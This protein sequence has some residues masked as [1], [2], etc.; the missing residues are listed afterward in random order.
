MFADRFLSLAGDVSRA[1]LIKY[2]Y[3]EAIEEGLKGEYHEGGGVKLWAVMVR[4]LPN[5]FFGE[6]PSTDEARVQSLSG[7]YLPNRIEKRNGL[8]TTRKTLQAGASNEYNWLDASMDLTL[9]FRPFSG[10]SLQGMR[11]FLHGLT[12][13]NGRTI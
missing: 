3:K 1:N 12:L 13:N 6:Y 7:T 9:I 2:G 5:Q 10:S 4:T 8:R 11:L